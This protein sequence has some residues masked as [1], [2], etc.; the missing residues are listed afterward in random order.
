MN[1]LV[2][3]PGRRHMRVV[4]VSQQ[5]ST[6]DELPV[7]VAAHGTTVSM[8]DMRSVLSACKGPAQVDAVAIRT[9]YGGDAFPEPVLVDDAVAERLLRL[10]PQAPLCMAQTV[11]LARAAA[12]SFPGLPIAL[13]FETSFFVDLPQRETTYALP[14]EMSGSLRRWGYHGLFHD[15]ATAE[16]ARELCACGGVRP[17]RMLSVCLETLPEIA[18]VL[19]RK[20][21]MVTSGATPL[22]GLPGESNSGE[23]DPAIALALAADK[24]LGPEGANAL[25]T[26]ESGIRGMLGRSATLAQVL[27]SRGARCGR[28]RDFLL[29]RMLLAAGSAVAS[30]GGLDG[31]AFSGRY[32]EAA[33]VVARY[34]LPRLE[35]AMNLAPGALPWRL[36]CDPI[37]ILVAEAGMSAVIAAAA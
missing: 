26:R 9:L 37:E 32:I 35:R 3:L 6:R 1:T 8:N 17:L 19:G 2:L 13:A 24:S 15:A 33:P 23:I 11:E 29:Y 21:L 5:R 14:S 34:L 31:V 18:A 27:T 28:V 20:P 36:L 16:M 4:H 12:A 22:E 7:Q 10:G 25:L 30:L